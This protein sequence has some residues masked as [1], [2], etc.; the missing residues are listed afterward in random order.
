MVHVFDAS[1][2]SWL[3]NGAHLLFSVTIFDASSQ[4]WLDNGAHLLVKNFGSIWIDLD[5]KEHQ[6]R[7][8]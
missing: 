5:Q 6:K 1:S 8:V 3:D 7:P 2:Q 4:S